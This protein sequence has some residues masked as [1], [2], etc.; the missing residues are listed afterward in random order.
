LL[1]FT[2]S[3]MPLRWIYD[4]PKQ[5]VEELA[6]QLGLSTDGS[7]DDLRKRVKQKWT[8]IEPYL[9]SQSTDKSSLTTM[10]VLQNRDPAE[11]QGGPLNK[12]KVKLATDLIAGIPVLAG[13]DPEA[14]LK[15]LIQARNILELNLV[16]GPEFVALMITRTSGRVMQILGAHVGGTRDWA[17]V[18]SEIVSTFLPPRVKERLLSSYVLDRFQGSR[19][20]LN[21]YIMAV[22]AAAAILGFTGTEQQLVHRML[23]NLHPKIRPHMLFVT[24]PESVSELFALATQVAEAVAVEEHRQNLA[25]PVKPEVS[26]HAFANAMVRDNLR[27]ARADGRVRCWGCGRNGHVQ[28]DCPIRS[29]RTG[30]AEGS[31]SGNATGAR[32]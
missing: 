3:T 23:Q 4:L 9:P 13:T 30:A 16:S 6:G 5:Q 10:P 8:A 24:E 17:G 32:Q 7:L 31:R 14:I 15:F 2:L 28:R 27:S 1:C 29:R 20:G 18:Q 22:V 11:N 25:T 26:T 19:E 12:A 21:D